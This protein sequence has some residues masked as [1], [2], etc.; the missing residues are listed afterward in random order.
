MCKWTFVT[1]IRFEFSQYMVRPT[2]VSSSLTTLLDILILMFAYLFPCKIRT[3]VC[4][5]ILGNKKLQAIVE[6]LNSFFLED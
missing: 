6:C 4:V 2:N 5:K 3:N 1:Q